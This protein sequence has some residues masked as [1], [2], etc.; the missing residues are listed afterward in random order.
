MSGK[1]PSCGANVELNDDVVTGE[2]VE[3]DEC[4]E[5]LEVTVKDDKV[6]LSTAPDVEEDWGE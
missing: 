1:C 2:I 4:G 5:E 6:T 3:C